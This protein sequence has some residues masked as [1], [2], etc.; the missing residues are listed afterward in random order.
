MR[1]SASARFAVLA[2]ALAS[3]L[4][5][6]VPADA[7]PF[8]FSTGNT[9]GK[10]ALASRPPSSGKIEIEAADDVALTESTSVQGATF[11]GLLPSAAPLSSISQVR[12]AIYRVFPLDSD[13]GR[14]TG[15]PTFST[16]LVPTRVNS[17]SDTEVGMRDSANGGLSF[18]PSIL[19]TSFTALN[20]VLNGINPKPNSQTGGE[21]AVSGEEVGFNVTF[22]PSLALPADHYFFVP[23]VTLSSG[24]FFWLSAARP[25]TAPGTPFPAGTTDLQAWIRNVGLEPDWL[26]VGTDVIGTGTFNATFSL[27]GV[28]CQAISPA[29]APPPGATAGAGYSATFSASGG[30]APYKFSAAGQLPSGLSFDPNGTLAGTPVESGSFPLTI[31][32]TGAEGCMG[33]LHTTLTVSPAPA[34]EITPVSPMVPQPGPSL[35]PSITSARLTPKTFRAATRG[36][37]ITRRRRAPQGTTLTYTDSEAATTTFRIFKPVIGHK[38]GRKCAAGRPRK[39]GLRCTRYVLSG[40]AT[41]TDAA[42]KTKVHFSGRVK[43]R[44]LR[45]GSYRLMLTPVAGGTV[46]KTVALTFRIVR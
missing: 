14:T 33:S 8:F 41:H 35:P 34:P 29:P 28:T 16:S 7:A 2:I 46:G 42:G 43:G 31:T 26:R 21:G 40:S 38:Q 44:K 9:D 32:A 37:T 23:Q 3:A 15:A 24:N 18:T 12:V 20:S 6:A 45:A 11:S 5:V 30:S 25:I 39:L 17:P 22:S 10:L 1:G 19:G 4:A 27:S 36:A 13:P